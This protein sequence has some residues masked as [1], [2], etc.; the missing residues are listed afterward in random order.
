MQQIFD[1]YTLEKILSTCALS[2]QQKEELTDRLMILEKSE[3]EFAEDEIY[4]IIDKIYQNQQD[5]IVSGN[6]Y[7]QRDIIRHLKKLK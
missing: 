6:N 5:H 7:G 4:Q 1:W 2:E 3:N